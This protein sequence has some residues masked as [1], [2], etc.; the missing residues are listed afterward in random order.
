MN[1][2]IQIAGVIDYAEA[3]MLL[4][5][6]VNFLG[7]P[8]RLPDGRE[9][10]SETQ[11]RE[12]VRLIGNRVHTVLITYLGKASEIAELSDYLGV[13]WVQLH[14]EISLA[15]L[16]KLRSRSPSLSIIRS[17]VVHGDNLS[18]LLS[19]VASVSEL[20]DAFITDTFD[21]RM[22]RRGAT[23]KIHDWR[24]SR[25]IAQLS[26]K[27]MILA[28]GLTPTNVRE[29]ILQVKPAGVDCHTGVEAPDGRKEP[30]L[31]HRFVAE[32]REGFRLISQ[33]MV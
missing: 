24:I 18:E 31:V 25:E 32:A 20:V 28:G 21:P 2:V 27:S 12:I 4:E 29:A 5:A 19:L 13:N 14:G 11:A 30:E 6:N 17:L 33:G 9:D 7:F 16:E 23:G 15:E 8:L 1:Q 26:P 10:L 22:G 3:S